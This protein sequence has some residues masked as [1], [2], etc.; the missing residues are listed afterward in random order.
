MTKRQGFWR[1]VC[2]WVPTRRAPPRRGATAEATA[3]ALGASTRSLSGEAPR[4]ASGD[5]PRLA[6]CARC[7]SD[8]RA[9]TARR[10]ALVSAAAH[11]EPISDP[12]DP[13]CYLASTHRIVLRAAAAHEITAANGIAAAQGIAGAHVIAV[14]RRSPWDGAAA[15]KIVAAQEVA[16][17]QDSPHLPTCCPTRRLVATFGQVSSSCVQH[18]AKAGRISANIFH[19]LANSAQ[20]GQ[21]GPNSVDV[22]PEMPIN[23]PNR[24]LRVNSG[25]SLVSF[26]PYHPTCCSSR[27]L[28]ADC[29]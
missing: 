10:S 25:R 20:I 8:A 9:R 11:T 28:S 29:V 26:R 12:A 14:D 22:W 21:F 17:T 7:G 23:D 27:V 24:P 1:G 16:A 18:W 19:N 3:E 4:I 2:R 6:F 15:Y 5:A 13:Q